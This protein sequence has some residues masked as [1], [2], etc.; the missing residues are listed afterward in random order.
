[1]TITQP[2]RRAIV[3]QEGKTRWVVKMQTVVMGVAPI[4]PRLARGQAMPEIP[5]VASTRMEAQQLAD[6]WQSWLDQIP[7]PRSS[8]RRKR[9]I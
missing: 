7:A 6:R 1:M 8:K 9:Q 5:K 3:V 4:G 2:L